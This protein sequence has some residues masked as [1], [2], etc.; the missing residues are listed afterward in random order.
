MAAQPHAVSLYF[1]PAILLAVHLTEEKALRV[2]HA[3]TQRARRKARYYLNA[4]LQHSFSSKIS[5]KDGLSLLI[6]SIPLRTLR[7]SASLRDDC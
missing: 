1:M 5:W 3:E 6:T 2:F 4:R 7:S